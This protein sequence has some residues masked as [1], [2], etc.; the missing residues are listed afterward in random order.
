MNY[1]PEQ[2][3]AAAR[4]VPETDNAWTRQHG[5]PQVAGDNWRGSYVLRY[6]QPWA[7]TEAGRSD[8]AGLD[9]AVYA[10]AYTN[11]L[12]WRLIGMVGDMRNAVNTGDMKQRQA[13]T[14]AAAIAIGQHMARSGQEG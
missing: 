7:D 12:P 11:P 2:V 13:A 4:L 1:T 8:W 5:K 9:T 3:A 6:W 10:Y 14:M